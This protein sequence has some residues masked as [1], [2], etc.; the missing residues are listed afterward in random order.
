MSNRLEAQEKLI[1]A[2]R[3]LID[4]MTAMSKTHYAV[5]KAVTEEEAWE[6]WTKNRLRFQTLKDPCSP[7]VGLD[8]G[9][10]LAEFCNERAEMKPRQFDVEGVVEQLITESDKGWNFKFTPYES[11]DDPWGGKVLP[12]YRKPVVECELC[13]EDEG[14][15]ACVRPSH[16]R[17]RQNNDIEGVPV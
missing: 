7:Y 16:W 11:P 12:R 5:P 17:N 2:Q 3:R 8:H 13:F 1:D 6:W 4:D 14:S 15:Y 9:K 10:A